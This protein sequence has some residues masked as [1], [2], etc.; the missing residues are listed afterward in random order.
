MR[1]LVW[2][3]LVVAVVGFSA[4]CASSTSGNCVGGKCLDL[5]G[6]GG[7]PDLST[8]NTTQPDL[9]V[10]TVQDLGP[11]G[12]FGDPCSAPKQCASQICVFAGLSG[13][14]SQFC[15]PDCPGGYGCYSVLGGGIDPG[16]IVQICVPENNQLCSVCTM[17]SECSSA[18]KDLCLPGPNGG[19]FCARDCTNVSCAA[20]YT[21]NTLNLSGITVKQ[22]QPNAPG[23]CDCRAATQ[24]GTT[25]ACSITTPFGTCNAVKTCG[26]AT[27]WGPCAGSG[28][29]VPD[30]VYKD[31]NCDGIDGDIT[32]GIFVAT[33]GT[34]RATSGTP[35]CGLTYND[36][37]RTVD[38]GLQRS[39][40]DSKKFVYVQA[41]IYT[42][43]VNLQAGKT[44]VG[45]YDTNWQ[46]A[47]RTVGGHETHLKGTSASGQY[48]AVKGQN[49]SVKATLMDLYVDGPDAVGAGKS[50][51]AIYSDN[52]KIDI[53]RVTVT[54]GNG[55]NGSTGFNATGYANPAPSSGMNASVGGDSNNSCETCNDSARGGG[56]GAGSNSCSGG[57]ILPSGGGGG[58]GG[59][60][61]SSCCAGQCA[62]FC[63]NCNATNGIHGSNAAATAASYYGLAGGDGATC[64]TA[65]NGNPGLTH[66]GA[67]GT[68]V[69]GNG[70]LA[71]GFW[72]AATGGGGSLGDHG[73]GGGG[74][75]GSGACDNGCDSDGAGGGGGGAGGCRSPEA[76]GGG[77]GGGGSFGVFAINS[78]AINAT[79]CSVQRGNG[80]TGGTGGTGGQGQNGGSGAGGGKSAGGT[81]AG[82]TGGDGAHGGNGGAGAGGAGGMSAAFFNLGSTVTQS[83]TISGG[84]AG[85]G[86][87]GGAAAGDGN[88]GQTGPAGYLAP[89]VFNCSSGGGC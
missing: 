27:G 37:C 62:A 2:A 63:G 16:E 75:G 59:T 50:T 70:A 73:S 39:V 12:M 68:R 13:V 47:A 58:S 60:K 34:D 17:S 28:T 88:A 14:C 5:G 61:D 74:A 8:P 86:G 82:G 7:N 11:L 43:V 32:A 89:N 57:S 22:C 20:G 24:A 21:C 25:S 38:F 23:A 77:T 41:G 55:V 26:G 83:C 40:E 29:D 44:V 71:S 69:L 79:I 81:Q 64:A 56:G 31:D 85:P 48:L 6:G 84:S 1:S 49:L 72:F 35:G 45:G 15:P 65:N 80:G 66:N 10:P 36:A 42:E 30:D 67:G 4:G 78:S 33:T 18:G 53:V 19:N 46:R 51:Y 76:G 54:A 9:S 3:G 87:T 52:A